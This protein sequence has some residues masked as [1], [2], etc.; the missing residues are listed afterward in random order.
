MAI[1]SSGVGSGLDI[2]GLVTQLVAAERSPTENRLVTKA[3]EYQGQI[4]AFGALKG[5]LSGFQSSLSSLQSLS[6]YNGRNATVSDSDVLTVRAGSTAAAPGTG[7]GTIRARAAALRA[8]GTPR[9]LGPPAGPR[10]WRASS[11]RVETH[12]SPA[13]R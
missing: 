2:E 7:R 5:A 11:G 13:P 8:E 3:A 1:T 10:K 12:S 4:S 6:T 9:Q